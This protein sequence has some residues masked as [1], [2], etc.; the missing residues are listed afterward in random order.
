MRTAA[1]FYLDFDSTPYTATWDYYNTATLTAALV[2]GGTA[3]NPG[4]SVNG[5]QI[6]ATSGLIYGPTESR[7]YPSL[8]LACSSDPLCAL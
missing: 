1:N 6:A 3:N 7:P 4:N 2:L 5:A 8:A